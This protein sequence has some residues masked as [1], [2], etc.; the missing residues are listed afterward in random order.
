MATPHTAGAAAILLQ[1]HPSWTPAELKAALM[2]SAKVAADQTSFQQGAGRIDL[3]TA[4]KQTV[5]AESGNVS[6]GT[7]TYPHS[8]DQPVTRDVT[9]RNLGDAA[10]TLSLTSV[11]NGPDGAAAPAG[12]LK[13]SADSVTVPAGGTASVQATSDTTLGGADGLYSG[14]IT[15]TG[16]DRRSSYRWV[17]TRKVRRTT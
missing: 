11:L 5:V 10:V 3:T 17:S 9:F 7:A 14:R 12:A 15:A 4:I 16:G 2:G 8:D 13:L 6:F 1:E